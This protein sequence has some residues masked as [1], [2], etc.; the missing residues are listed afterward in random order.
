MTARITKRTATGRVRALVVGTDDRRDYDGPSLVFRTT[1][2][3]CLVAD[4]RA[5]DVKNITDSQARSPELASSAKG[6]LADSDLADY[7]VSS[8][9]SLDKY[10]DG[11]PPQWQEWA[12]YYNPFCV[13]LP[14]AKQM[15]R[16]LRSIERRRDRANIGGYWWPNTASPGTFIATMAR[17]LGVQ[18][19]LFEAGRTGEWGHAGVIYDAVGI[20]EAR[21]RIDATYTAWVARVA[22]QH[23][24]GAS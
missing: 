4:G 21:G 14:R 24:L 11:N 6:A 23:A 3:T 5:A 12:D 19:V 15:V 9:C 8:R 2:V 18:A 16:A 7:E 17:V 13:D 22:P 20:E 10:A 1:S